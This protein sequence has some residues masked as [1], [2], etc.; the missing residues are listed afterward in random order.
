MKQFSD[1]L[2]DKI[3]KYF[4]D[5]VNLDHFEKAQ[6]YAIVNEKLEQYRIE[7]ENKIDLRDQSI[8][9]FIDN[10]NATHRVA[11]ERAIDEYNSETIEIKNTARVENFKEKL[12][13]KIKEAFNE[14]FST[15]TD[16]YQSKLKLTRFF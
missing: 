15:K 16:E 3:G 5:L 2:K 9:K 12:D 1:G 13:E 6:L 14:L 4:N 11:R 8:T 10:T 7:M